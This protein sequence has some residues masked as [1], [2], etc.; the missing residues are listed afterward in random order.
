MSAVVFGERFGGA[1]FAGMGLMLL[2]VAI[3]AVPLR[4]MALG[5]A[6]AFGRRA[7]DTPGS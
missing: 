6:A 2:G 4:S 3:V 7:D 5:W 1:R